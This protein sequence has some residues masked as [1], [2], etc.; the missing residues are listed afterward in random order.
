[1]SHLFS[2]AAHVKSLTEVLEFIARHLNL[3]LSVRLWNG[4]EIPLGREVH[5]N[6]F[7]SL[8]GPG[9]VGT[10]L[11]RPTLETVTRLYA[12][13]HIDIHGGNLLDI[14]AALQTNGSSRAAIRQISK[15]FLAKKALPFLF[16]KTSDADLEH[17]YTDDMVGRRES[18]RV[19]M[20]YIQFHYDAGNDFYQLF[21]DAEMQYT[22]G[23]YKDWNNSLEQSQ[24][25]K[26]EMICRKLRLEPGESMLDMGCGWGGLICYAASNH[27]V[28]AH[29]VTLS[30]QQ[31]DFAQ[32]KIRSQGLEDLVTVEDFNA[33]IAYGL[34]LP[35]EYEM[36]SP[37]GRPFRVAH[38]GV[39]VKAMFA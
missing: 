14:H 32:A 27:G 24:L 29:G 28:K 17:G 7:I 39:P 21:L 20:Q 9:V 35:T 31:Y 23:Y 33:T 30:K 13:G 2:P 6:L 26:M 19:N 12:Q 38:K 25:D 3:R 11:R 10:L 16:T 15:L 1:M 22:C 18:R 4:D 37:S 8:S 34:G 5:A 36:Y